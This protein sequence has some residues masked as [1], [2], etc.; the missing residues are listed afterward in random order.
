MQTQAL[1]AQGLS[2]FML[3]AQGHAFDRRTGRSYQ[4]NATGQT[5][6]KSLQE[7][8]DLNT[9]VD[10]LCRSTTQPRAAVA[11]AVDAFVLQLAEVLA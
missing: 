5:V 8:S 3:S 2:R 6:L 9:V 1:S 7:G 4:L 10:Q 11:A